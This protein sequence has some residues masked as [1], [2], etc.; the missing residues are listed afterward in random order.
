MWHSGPSVMIAR[1]RDK[2]P[3]VST[4]LD[5]F[6]NAGHTIMDIATIWKNEK[7][8]ITS[9]QVRCPDALPAGTLTNFNIYI[10]TTTPNYFITA[11]QGD[12]TRIL[13]EAMLGWAG[14]MV[15][16]GAMGDRITA[17]ING[18]AVAPSYI[19]TVD[20]TYELLGGPAALIV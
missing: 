12:I 14:G 2:M 13:P 8:M 19:T 18:S 5:L 4:T 10:N 15:M 17:E 11:I 7:I 16:D 9:L 20:I 6:T 1:E 3:F